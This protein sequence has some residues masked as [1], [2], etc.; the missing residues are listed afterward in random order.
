[1]KNKVL[2]YALAVIGGSLAFF[3]AF[4]C[5][6]NAGIGA[7]ILAWILIFVLTTSRAKGGTKRKLHL[8]GGLEIAVFCLALA[9][10]NTNAREILD[11]LE[12]VSY[13]YLALSLICMFFS[14][15][16]R[17]TRWYYILLPTKKISIHSLFASIMI[18]FM[19]NG[20]LP[21]RIGEFLRAYSISRK[22]DIKITTSIA[23]IALERILDG[24]AV[25]T[26]LLILIFICPIEE[27]EARLDV[28][29]RHIGII[30]TIV[31]MA[32]IAFLVILRLKS[33]AFLR[34]TE[35]LVG[36]V[37]KGI[38]KKVSHILDSFL[39]GLASLKSPSQLLQI[40]FHSV[41]VWISILGVY[42]TVLKA[43]SI[44]IP[45]YGYLLL[46][47]FV[48]IGVLI[49]TPGFI[50]PFH[51]FFKLALTKGFAIDPS[52]AGACAIIAH[53]LGFVP[54][55]IVGLFYFLR[56]HLSLKEVE[57]ASEEP[58]ASV[59]EAK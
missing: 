33:E 22:E 41:L 13:F 50:G 39:L 34:I 6:D 28:P 27:V 14:M 35:K 31:Y 53:A 26:L 55:V 47:I 49:P 52:L 23:T 17:A 48:V 38:A 4:T 25:I 21:M 46:Q 44:Q 43:F 40:G 1:M 57:E 59:Q 32:A 12:G 7:A 8:I 16:F 20:V 9:Y 18:G 56:E 54:V 29:I 3:I 58:L 19:G 24:L 42:V 11:A 51:Y 37:S 30:V 36:L 10:R 5:T 2:Q 15:F 45:F